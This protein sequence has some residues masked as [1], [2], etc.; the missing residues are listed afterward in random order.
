MANEIREAENSWIRGVGRIKRSV[1]LELLMEEARL[2]I[3]R[4]YANSIP[5]EPCDKN[6]VPY[7]KVYPPVQTGIFGWG[8]FGL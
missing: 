7:E 5:F 3:V 6:M 8:I 2:N 4:G 1:P